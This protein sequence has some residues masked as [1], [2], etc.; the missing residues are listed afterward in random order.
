MNKVVLTY[1]S[2]LVGILCKLVSSM[3]GYEQDTILT[4]SHN[5]AYFLN[6]MH[7]NNILYF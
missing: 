5:S 6:H 1:V 3:H 7:F 2:A 4:A